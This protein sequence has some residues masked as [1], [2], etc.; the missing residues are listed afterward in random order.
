MIRFLLVVFI[1]LF[2]FY[3]NFFYLPNRQI[4]EKKL[5]Y[6]EKPFLVNDFSHL[7]DTLY[8]AG[9]AFIIVDL[10][11]QW[12]ELFL[13]N[14]GSKK[15]PVSSGN[16]RLYKAVNTSEGLFV[17][18]AKLPKWHSRQFD[19]TLMLNWMGFSFGIG[20]HA[21]AGKSYYRYL[22]K[23]PSS[24]GCLRIGQEDAKE[25]YEIVK[26]G[27]PVLVHSKNN[28]VT[29]DFTKENQKLTYYNYKEFVKVVNKRL[30]ALYK[31]I[32][33]L[34][35]DENLIIAD[36]VFHAGLPIGNSEQI[37]SNQRI[38]EFGL[39]INSTAKDITFVTANNT[40]IS[41]S[42]KMKN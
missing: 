9:D 42:V 41:D 33:Y 36:N 32:Y 16:G 6:P 19:S 28:A 27:T 25:I 12:A 15:F 2:S 39:D 34:E 7:K 17:L 40:I 22:G 29:I 31:G 8:F 35:V 37:P 24:H 13:R 14:G 21:L 11:D 18:K 5:K 38:L 1:M 4:K 10:V 30:D 23:K 26:L 3:L 20:F